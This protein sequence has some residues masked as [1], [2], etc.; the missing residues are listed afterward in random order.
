IHSGLARAGKRGV[1]FFFRGQ[2]GKDTHD[3]WRYYDLNTNQ[4]IDNRYLIAN[5]IA[6]EPDAPR[7][8]GDYDVFDLQE[9]VIADILKSHEEQIGLEATPATVDPIQQTVATTLQGYLNS[10]SLKRPRVLAAIRYVNTPMMGRQVKQLRE[11]F[12][13]FK[14]GQDIAALMSGIEEMVGKYGA[15]TRSGSRGQAKPLTREDLHLICF[16]HLCS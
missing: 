4:I 3:F 15:Q 1:F 8:V 9:K 10:T 14:S 6:C 12:D 5:L 16:D 13:T 2:A 7:V 11:L